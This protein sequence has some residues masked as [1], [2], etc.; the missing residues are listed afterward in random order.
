MW[1]ICGMIAR[2]FKRST[3][4]AAAF[5]RQNSVFMSLVR[6]FI[7]KRTGQIVFGLATAALSVGWAALA[8][9]QGTDAPPE[10][11]LFA[12]GGLALPAYFY[13]LA[14]AL[15]LLVPVGVLLI[16]VSGLEAR[17]AWN[18]AVGALGALGLAALAY[19]AVGFAFQFGGVGLIYERADLTLLVLEWSPLPTSWG[20]GWGVVGLSGWFLSSPDATAIVYALF[21]AHLPWAITAAMIPVVA[22]RGRAPVAATLTLAALIGGGIYP[23]AGNWVQGGGWLS[24]LGRNLELGHGFVDFGGAGSVFLVAAGIALAALVVWM[25]RKPPLQRPDQVPLPPVQLPLLSVVGSLLLLVGALG[26]LWTNPLQ[27]ATLREVDLLRGSV[28]L[29]LFA[30]GGLLIPLLYT[31][32]V[33][34]TSDPVMSARG[35]T[36]G[37]VAGLAVGPFVAPGTAFV[38]GLVAGAGVPF[39]TYLIDARLRLDDATG[40][41][42]AAAL[43]ALWGLLAVGIFAD[44]T[45]GVGWQVTGVESYLGVDGQ[46]VSGLLTAPRF[47]VDF[48][49]QL[50]AQV[51]G[52]L[53]LGLWGFL[54]GLLLCTPL[55][56]A[57][58]ALQR[59]MAPRSEPVQTH[60]DVVVA[61]GTALP[62]PNRAADPFPF[63]FDEEYSERPE[64][65]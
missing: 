50:Q 42:T 40:A 21:L 36:A 43:P 56:L 16:G 65:R 8:L 25:P 27:T 59:S 4:T 29:I 44:G 35:L 46:G 17:R 55:G 20:R 11:P 24:A 63:E 32:F 33:T 26:W 38:I 14:A 22:L 37:V 39:A 34:A 23:L 52:A 7:F 9:A 10:T 41:V 15:S 13:L 64:R 18:A 19:W 53:A 31:W 58:H 30:G 28:N 2:I 60:G 62:M 12:E 6:L 48:P 5:W 51:I 45:T 47:A 3:E 1:D 61:P 54:L 57:S 49:G